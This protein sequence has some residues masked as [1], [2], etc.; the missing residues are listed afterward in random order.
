MAADT[1]RPAL[2]CTLIGLAIGVTQG[3]EVG[4]LPFG[5]WGAEA[6]ER[7]EKD[8][9]LPGKDLYAE[10]G[11]GDGK[12]G[13]EH[14]GY[15]FV[16]PAG[17]QL[18]ALAAAARVEPQR[19]RARLV[20]LAD[21]LQQYW[22]VKS[23]VGGFAVLP[24][25][26]ERYYDDNAWLALCL[27][28]TARVT[29]QE[30]YL[31]QASKTLAFVAGG[32]SKT[33]GGGIRQHE[34]KPGGPVVCATAPATIAALQLY[35][36][37]RNRKLLAAAE[38]WY[39]WMMA[40]DVGVQ[41]P[42]DGLFHQGAELV[43]GKWRVKEGKRAYQSALPLRSCLL[44]HE[45]KKDAKY[46]AEAQRIAKS[47]L[48][49]W[50]LPSGAL[51]EAGQWGGSDLCDALLDLHEVDRNPAWLAAVHGILRFLHDNVRDPQGRYGENWHE[52]HR[53]APLDKF[54]LL[55]MAPV[56]RGY[57]RAAMNLGR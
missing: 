22:C 40:A 35:Q 37:S 25:G 53:D 1:M 39:G 9:A 55:H 51:R 11:T 32:E 3:T 46:L 7:I 23:G 21:A 33:L 42:R 50:V 6:L 13:S 5:T 48:A 28:E 38:R 2:L 17:H 27:I 52:E 12:R 18:Y 26:S 15:S 10:W 43:D 41:D 19:Y 36:S 20:R 34:D 47:A 45:I 57:W 56:A 4:Q 16:W 24:R 29:R 44:L 30:K 49:E 8:L 54:L 31:A 14:E